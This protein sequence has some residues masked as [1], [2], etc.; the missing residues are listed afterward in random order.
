MNKL[1]KAVIGK[2]HCVEPQIEVILMNSFKLKQME[3]NAQIILN[4]LQMLNII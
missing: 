3:M 2:M 1:I 4:G